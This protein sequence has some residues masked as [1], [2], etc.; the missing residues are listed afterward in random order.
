[1]AIIDAQEDQNPPLSDRDRIELLEQQVRILTDVV[2][3]LGAYTDRGVRYAINMPPQAFV[4]KEGVK[5]NHDPGIGTMVTAKF[6][7]FFK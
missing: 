6:P 1:M 5:L 7:D 2:R 3:Y 4:M